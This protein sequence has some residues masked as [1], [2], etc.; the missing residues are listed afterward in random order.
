MLATLTDERFSSPDWLFERKLDGERCLVFRRK[1]HLHMLSRNRQGLNASYPELVDAL[2]VQPPQHYI[3]DGEIVSF[4]GTLTSF[5]RL[6]GRIGVR[7]PEQARASGIK[8]YLYLFDL[9]FLERFDVTA[10]PLRARKE[11]LRRAF[12]FG[13][14]LLRF[15][16]H[17]NADGESLYHSA[18]RKGWEGIIAKRA[19]SSYRHNRSRS[20][21][22]FKCVKR[23]E[24]VI[25]G[26]TTP[27]G[28]RVGFGA[29]LLGYYRNGALQYAG[30]VGTGFDTA[31]L[32]ALAER[33]AARRCDDCPFAEPP[34]A[35]GSGVHWV[36]PE[37]VAEV[38]FTEWT[39]GQRLRHPRFLGLRRD[40]P[41]RQV[42]REESS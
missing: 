7:D 25:G 24:L 39:A 32:Q 3:V 27:R 16:A 9:L 42:V 33:L 28:Q 31:T 5:S 22:K 2:A 11:M 38:G 6:Q 8:V 23:Q 35:P 20:W 10:L 13:A 14:P 15:T 18:C 34:D 26:Y 37:L 40:K 4:A 29:L 21:L 41:A 12:D 17:R 19:D 30:K 36:K 1:S